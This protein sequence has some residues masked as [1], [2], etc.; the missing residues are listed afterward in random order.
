MEKSPLLDEPVE[1]GPETSW[2]SLLSSTIAKPLQC[3][4]SISLGDGSTH[5][6]FQSGLDADSRIEALIAL[7]QPLDSEP[8][9]Q[10]P[11]SDCTVKSSLTVEK[12]L[13]KIRQLMKV[14]GVAVYIVPSEDEHQSE[15][16][17]LADKRR[18]FLSGFTGSAGLCV[19]TLDSDTN[20]EGEAAL[21]TDG[22]YFLQAEKQLD[23]RFWRLLKQGV[24]G[25]PSW[26]EFA[27]SKAAASKFSSV[28]SCDPKLL[29]FEM[30]EYLMLAL[31]ERGVKF[32]PILDL[33][34]VDAV[35][36][37]DKPARS[38]EPVYLLPLEYSG[39]ES[40][41]KIARI[42][43]QM[44]GLGASHLVI[45]AL[46]D[47]GWLLNLRADEDIPFSPFFFSYLILTHDYV[48][49]Y[50]NEVKL[51]NVEQHLA[52]ISGLV[53]KKYNFFYPDL[54]TLRA[55]VKHPNI[56]IILPDKG[57][58]NYALLDSIPNSLAKR[59]II[60]L[61]IVSVTKLFKN[62]TEL[63]NANVAH[64]RDSLAF[65]VFSAWLENQLV[66]RRKKV[67][68][69]EAAQKIYAIRSQF[70]NFKGLS[71]ETISSTGANAAIIHY[72][73]TKKENSVIDPKKPYLLDS[74][75]HYL[76]GTTD[77]TRTYKFG[78]A[79]LT[80]DYKKYYTLVLKGHL[81]VAMAKF[82]AGSRT[83]GTVL[84]AYARQPLWNEGLDFNHGTG[85]GVGSFGNVHEGPL[86]IL[87]TSGGVSTADYFK[88][89]AIV[90]DEPGFYIDGECGF[91]IESEL[92]V[93][94]CSPAF[95][96]T[97]S[98]GKYLGFQYLTKVP[99]CLKL[100]DKRFLTPI[101][102]KWINDFNASLREEF[103]SKLLKMGDKRAY[104][105]LLKETHPI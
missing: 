15:E 16:T 7:E 14:H 53:V 38:L 73:P 19:V 20:L 29:S 36:G 54:T 18:E 31:A 25:H 70:P 27:L 48:W 79:G 100:I 97:R 55:T 50:A 91:R 71:Y 83:T 49:L 37:T 98:G 68:E 96:K 58:C 57:A 51:A 88:K 47:I 34:F 103:G 95:G 52:E 89:G 40:T 28:I 99:F 2:R 12:K 8:L 75:A 56:K 62:P 72:A 101:E 46:D 69:Y 65:I 66:H 44:H 102:I 59:S 64:S 45:S 6:S 67:L 84:D 24:R 80:D 61:S 39:E 32:K 85:H 13:L 81:A 87:T 10:L 17:A 11:F 43:N 22:R 42:R 74:G 21:S 93:I 86:Y 35:W 60:H 82:P 105:W 104:G 9:P 30:G 26:Q 94:E 1:T 23:S 3:I 92:A 90:S 77:I 76:E 5:S 4:S 63:H 41:R 78:D 33:N